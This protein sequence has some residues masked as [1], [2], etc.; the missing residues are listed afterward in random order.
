[1]KKMVVLIIVIGVIYV[2][3]ALAAEGP[4]DEAWASFIKAGFAYQEGQYDKAIA[5]Y[6]HLRQQGLVSGALY[7]NLA[8]A[9]FKKGQVGK[10]I[11][12]YER[13][14]EILPRDSDVLSNYKLTLSRK[15]Q[16]FPLPRK[17]MIQRG[18]E[19][20]L[21]YYTVNEFLVLTV[22]FT[23]MAGGLF[24]AAL[25][26]NWPR[27]KIWP[28]MTICLTLSVLCVTG[29]VVRMHLRAGAGFAVSSTEAFFEP[30]PDATVHFTLK[31]G[32]TVKV[33]KREGAW[34]KIERPDQKAGWVAANT[35]ETI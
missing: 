11:L 4:R 8:N 26:F 28:V 21:N 25:F 17:S 3:P 20:A 9:Y 33:L 29:V 2:L 15:E 10:A 16:N 5:E 19:G 31:E 1:M 34:L 30:R 12:N 14:R 32:Q 13:A 22:L 23:V 6:E 27:R 24:L 7:Y 18:V 35:V